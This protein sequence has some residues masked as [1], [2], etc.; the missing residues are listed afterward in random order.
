MGAYEYQSAAAA[1]VSAT[2]TIDATETVY[3]GSVTLFGDCNQTIA[4]LNAVG[5]QP[6]QGSVT[7]KVYVQA[8]TPTVNNKPYVRRY[9]EVKAA[10]NA[11]TATANL[12][13]YFTQA[14]FDAYNAVRG[15]L[16]S[17][18]INAADV[19]GYKANVQITQQH[20]SSSTG[21]PGSYTGWA[22]TG[23]ANILITPSLVAWNAAASRWEVTISVTGFSGFFLH[24]GATFPLPLTL[25]AFSG[26]NISNSLN[27]LEWTTA[28]EEPDTRYTIERSGDGIAFAAIGTVTGQGMTGGSYQLD[29]NAPLQG[30]NYYRLNI[31]EAGPAEQFSNTVL[32]K[33]AVAIGNDVTVGPVPATDQV[34]IRC[35]GQALLGRE[36]SVVD[37]DGRVMLRF[38]LQPE[39]VVDV[40]QWAAG[41][42]ILRLP[43]G[44][45]VRIVRK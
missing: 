18:P 31:L 35:T 12:T 44:S 14:D 41:I 19:A 10:S 34:V 13:F 38:V 36:A 26:Q 45:G 9:Y 8:A 33:G 42:Y 27:R 2:A 29:D 15:T 40:Q 5:A 28:K 30:D 25:I 11:S 37:M 1:P 21:M 32:I 3:S 16:P 4:A 7:A 24:T 22:G 17:L 23:P 39:T 20:G 43:D 6:V